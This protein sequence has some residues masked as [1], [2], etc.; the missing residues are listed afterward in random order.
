M[1][2]ELHGPCAGQVFF[3]RCQRDVARSR[4]PR[5]FCLGCISQA[6]AIE[7]LVEVV[8]RGDAGGKA[9]AAWAL[10]NLACNNVDN[11]AAPFRYGYTQGQL[12]ELS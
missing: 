11:E 1:G 10:E 2:V 5:R 12:Q 4:V 3:R 6:A 7:P 8:Q 9:N